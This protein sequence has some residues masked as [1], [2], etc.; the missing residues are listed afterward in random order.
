MIIYGGNS[1][2]FPKMTAEEIRAQLSPIQIKQAE[3][4]GSTLAIVN[5]Q[6]AKVSR[7]DI[8]IEIPAI[9]VEAG[10]QP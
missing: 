4:A 8:K 3:L 2:Q 9:E 5:H 7:N 10:P 6:L 1:K